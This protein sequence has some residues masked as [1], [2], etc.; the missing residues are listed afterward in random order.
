MWAAVWLYTALMLVTGAL[1]QFAGDR[2]DL[3]MLL[4]FGPRHLLLVP[5][6]PL[7]V[8]ALFG[9]RRALWVVLI[10]ALVTLFAVAGWVVSWPLGSTPDNAERLRIVTYNTDRSAALA[11][12]IRTSLAEWR[13][14]VVL[15]QDCKTVVADSLRAIG[16]PG[17]HVTPHFCLVTE[18]RLRRVSVLPGARQGSALR[19]DL[20]VRGQPV[21]VYQVHLIT[22]RNALWPALRGDFAGLAQSRDAREIDARLVSRWVDR[23]APGLVVAGDFNMVPQS[24]IYRDVWGDLTNAFSATGQGFGFT[25]FAGRRFKQSVRIDHVLSGSDYTPVSVTHYRGY[26]SEHQ[27]VLA[28]LVRVR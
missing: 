9:A 4:L 26:P 7:A 11:S 25:M 16:V 3:G 1:V 23:T 20:E 2:T 12:R 22:P 17:L 13:A 15:L 6:I 19:Y 14:D 28:E 24:G 18:H 5:W 21:T 8:L 27:P 10:G